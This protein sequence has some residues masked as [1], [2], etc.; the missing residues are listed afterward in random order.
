MAYFRYGTDVDLTAI[1]IC[2]WMPRCVL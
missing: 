2:F 1:Y